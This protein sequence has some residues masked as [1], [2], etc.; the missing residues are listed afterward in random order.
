MTRGYQPLVGDFHTKVDCNGSSHCTVVPEIGAA[1]YGCLG[2]PGEA[3]STA[4]AELAPMSPVDHAINPTTAQRRLSP[5]CGPASHMMVAT[6]CGR[7]PKVWNPATNS[8]ENVHSDIAKKYPSCAGDHA[9]ELCREAYGPAAACVKEAQFAGEELV[10]MCTTD[11]SPT[12]GLTVANIAVCTGC[13]KPDVC[14]GYPAVVFPPHPSFPDDFVTATLPSQCP[15]SCDG[16]GACGCPANMNTL[17][18]N[19]CECACDDGWFG[20]DC[21][22]LVPEWSRCSMD[23]LRGRAAAGGHKAEHEPCISAV[24]DD[25]GIDVQLRLGKAM[26]NNQMLHVSHLRD[27]QKDGITEDVHLCVSGDCDICANMTSV[28]VTESSTKICFEMHGTCG[29]TKLTDSVGCF[30]D[31]DVSPRCFTECADPTCN[32]HGQCVDGT[33][34]CDDGW[35]GHTCAWNCPLDCGADEGRGRCMKDGCKCIRRYNGDACQFDAS[36]NLVVDPNLEEEYE[37]PDEGTGSGSTKTK[38]AGGGVVIFIIFATVFGAAAVGY[39]VY[40][41]RRS[42]RFAFR[43]M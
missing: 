11:A 40:N 28:E 30:L 17:A 31:T 1:V 9:A 43:E 37:T 16:H 4:C 24:A 23:V 3:P 33:C 15:N 21:S 29:A 34:E 38:S 41:K 22:S 13:P 39:Y 2:C 26:V 10:H 35:D 42:A 8:W 36:G 6:E 14:D 5:Q 25:C 32:G 27:L 19:Q 18:S 7:R 20:A 12:C